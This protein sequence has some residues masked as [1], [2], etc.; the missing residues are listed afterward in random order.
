MIK[1]DDNKGI[2]EGK[3]RKFITISLIAHIM[4][5]LVILGLSFPHIRIKRLR[6]MKPVRVY[7]VEKSRPVEKKPKPKKTVHTR[8]KNP[9]V[10]HTPRPTPPKKKV[11][12]KPTRKT[13]KKPKPTPTPERRVAKARH[14][15]RP[16]K[17]RKR[18]RPTPVP[19]I[20]RTPRPTPVYRS[21]QR[22]R[23]RTRPSRATSFAKPT[24]ALVSRPETTQRGPIKLE[25]NELPA[26]YLESVKMRIESNF[27]VPQHLKNTPVQC[28]IQ[29]TIFRDGRIGNIQILKSTGSSI[30]DN[31]AVQAL[32]KTGQLGPLP[33]TF[34]RQSIQVMLTFDFSL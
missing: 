16:K 2:F 28:T 29:F 15:P 1:R 33:D 32:E 6:E 11:I 19:E 10:R 23:T 7:A 21:S 27:S 13:V 3:G 12:K 4:V 17:I 18:H 20:R 30:M 9:R 24:P 5:F 34:T 22:E 31:L 14:T 25:A 8:Q 26:F